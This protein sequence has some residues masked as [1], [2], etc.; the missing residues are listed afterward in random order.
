MLRIA[1]KHALVNLYTDMLCGV[2]ISATLSVSPRSSDYIIRRAGRTPLW[3]VVSED[4][5][6]LE[7]EL[8]ADCPPAQS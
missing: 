2:V 6:D 1:N 3:F 8:P 4:F 7:S 5:P